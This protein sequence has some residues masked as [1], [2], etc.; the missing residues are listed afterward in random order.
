M[1]WFHWEAEVEIGYLYIVECFVMGNQEKHYYGHNKLLENF[2][3][4]LI[5]IFNTIMV[6]EWLQ[7]KV[8]IYLFTT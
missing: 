4:T 2:T 1:G 5:T 7:T 8:L 6:K 3:K